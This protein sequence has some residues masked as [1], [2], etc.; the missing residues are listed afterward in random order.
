MAGAGARGMLGVAFGITPEA[1][2]FP[3]LRE[4]FFVAYEAPHAAQHAGVRGRAGAHRRH[5]ARGLPGAWSPTNRCAF[6]DP[7]TRAMPLFAAQVPS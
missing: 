2:E 4:E 3:E 1:P 6:T 5:C 7:L